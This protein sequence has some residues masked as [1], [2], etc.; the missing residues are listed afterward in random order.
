MGQELLGAEATLGWGPSRAPGPVGRKT[1]R[2]LHSPWP[3]LVHRLSSCP[4]LRCPGAIYPK[5]ELA[6]LLL[7]NRT[8][9]L[10]ALHGHLQW[11]RR[12]EE[13]PRGRSPP[14]LTFHIPHFGNR[15]NGGSRNK[16]E[17]MLNLI[18]GQP[19]GA[20]ISS[21][22]HQTGRSPSNVISI[23]ISL[24]PLPQHLG[25]PGAGLC[26]ISSGSPL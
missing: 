6:C 7:R 20:R 9:G 4:R 5:G 26:W 10:P 1:R 12:T 25:L 3:S 23:P 13:S 14:H 17:K 16:R 18:K 11:G 22:A 21:I 19:R 15:H 24:F 2:A 8:A